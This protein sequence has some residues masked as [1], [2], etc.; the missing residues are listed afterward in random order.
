VD[1]GYEPRHARI[2]F[3]AFEHGIIKRRTYK[4]Q[5]ESHDEWRVGHP[6]LFPNILLVGN[7]FQNT[8]QFR[9]PA[10]D[11]HT[12]HFS[13]YTWRAAPGFEAPAQDVV[14]SRIVP[15]TEPDGRLKV[16]ILFNQDYMCW[17]TQGPVAHRELEKL[18]ESDKGIILF[19]RQLLQQMEMMR[20]GGEPAMNVFRDPAENECIELGIEPSRFGMGDLRK[21][22]PAEAGYS[23]D[24]DKINAVME[25]WHQSELD[26]DRVREL[27]SV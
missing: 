9:V 24:A 6:V 17:I 16:D 10:D 27:V 11:S 21:Y 1:E 7:P 26:A 8:L 19:R 18:G 5:D 4:G 14:P 15:L 13:M 25:T 3:D 2:G 20:D 12:L 22:Q 23:A